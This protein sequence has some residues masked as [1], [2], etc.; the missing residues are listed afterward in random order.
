MFM[1]DSL[2]SRTTM[3]TT[4]QKTATY[5]V[6][7]TK[8]IILFMVISI[9][10]GGIFL[11][12]IQAG[13]P[14]GWMKLL[15]MMCFGAAGILHVKKMRRNNFANGGNS[16]LQFSLQL[17]VLIFLLLLIAY[18]I[19]YPEFILMA[20]GS[21]SAFVL[22]FIIAESWITLNAFLGI[23]YKIWTVP[24]PDT[25]EKTFIFFGG[26]PIRIIFSLAANDRNKKLLKSN[27]PLEK[28]VGEFYNHFLLIQRNNNRQNIELKD[29]NQNHFGWKFFKI[30]MW[31]LRKQQLDP[32]ATFEELGLK[33][34]STILA[35]RVKLA[36]DDKQQ[37]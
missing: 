7:K 4:Y 5:W 12:S 2:L 21:A 35:K 13:M 27:A 10:F 34:H 6:Q 29:E 20:L 26:V 18:Y 15:Q 25:F 16:R 30:D 1:Q 8:Y 23:E 3:K 32:E 17:F 28:S 24:V 9:A 22:P 11:L 14:L 19:I 31:G 33:N 36:E 37:F